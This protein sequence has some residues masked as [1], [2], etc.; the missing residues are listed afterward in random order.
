MPV[1]ASTAST[2]FGGRN[3]GGGDTSRSR[4]RFCNKGITL[5][6]HI[7]F[8]H[9]V[10][11]TALFYH[12]YFGGKWEG[13]KNCCWR[14]NAPNHSHIMCGGPA[15]NFKSSEYCLLTK[16]WNEILKKNCRVY[17]LQKLP[18]ISGILVW[19]WGI[20]TTQQPMKN[21]VHINMNN[22]NVATTDANFVIN[23]KFVNNCISSFLDFSDHCR[24]ITPYFTDG[25]DQFPE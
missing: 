5:S 4:A 11:H 14:P 1:F 23:W 21:A 6:N 10:P 24:S 7:K 22:V 2:F 17:L 19:P 3:M 12:L 16:P 9:L 25:T 13:E 20:L 8:Y 18:I 15:W